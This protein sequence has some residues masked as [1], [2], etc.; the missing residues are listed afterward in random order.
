MP[1]IDE[2]LKRIDDV[3]VQNKR[4]EWIYISLTVLLFGAGISCI[5]VALVSGQFAWSTPS[6][7]TTGLLYW[8]LKEIKSIRQ[9][10]IALATA[11]MLITQLPQD[12]AAEEI[13]KLLQTLYSED[14]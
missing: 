1:S 2:I 12:K 5:V 14:K 7:I 4:I 9:K 13:Q 10:N 3:L 8:P 11:P 6:A